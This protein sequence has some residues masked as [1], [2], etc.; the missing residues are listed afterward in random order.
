MP[1]RK[2]QSDNVQPSPSLKQKLVSFAGRFIPPKEVN[3][4]RAVAAVVRSGFKSNG[5][6]NLSFRSAAQSYD[7]N[8][9]TVRQRFH[10]RPSHRDAAESQMRVN[11]AQE[12]IIKEHMDECAVRGIPLGPN[13]VKEAAT[14]I[15]GQLCGDRWYRGFRERNPDVI[16]KVA[17]PLEAP[18][19]QALNRS[20]VKAFF[21][22]LLLLI[23]QYH[24][25]PH[26]IYN[27]D[28]KGIMLGKGSKPYVLVDRNIRTVS[29]LENGNR[30]N[31]TVIECICA[32][33]T[34]IRPCVIFKG[35]KCN[36]EWGRN[37]ECNARY[38]L[39]SIVSDK[40]LTTFHSISFSD[41][42]WTDQELGY[43][44]L[45]KDF[46]PA[47]VN[48]AGEGWRLLILDGHNS[49][50]TYPFCIFAKEHKIL[51]VCLPP[52]TTHVL[53]PC[54]VGV[55]GPL[56]SA[57]RKQVTLASHEFVKITPYNFIEF[58]STARTTSVTPHTIVRAFWKTGISPF[59]PSIIPE[60][61]FAPSRNTTVQAAPTVSM[62]LPALLE[63]VPSEP[64]P[65]AASIPP[66]A[67]TDISDDETA[68]VTPAAY[69]LV[70]KP[71]SPALN[72]P[73]SAWHAYAEATETYM[74][75]CEAALSSGYA[76]QALMQQ[77]NGALRSRLHDK[78][79][80]K[81]GR[82]EVADGPRHMTDNEM[83]D[84]LKRRDFRDEVKALGT[85]VLK[86][87]VAKI[88]ELQRKFL[89]EERE[90]EK[91]VVAARKAAEREQ[92][93]AEKAAAAARKAAEREQRGA[94]KAAVAAR[95]A[96][97]REHREAEKAAEKE[98]KETEKARR[99]A[100]KA[101]R[102]AR[103]GG[104]EAARKKK[105]EE[106]AK[107]KQEGTAV[108]IRTSAKKRKA[109]S[110]SDQTKGKKRRTNALDNAA[111]A[112]APSVVTETATAPRTCPKP[113]PVGKA[114]LMRQTRA[115]RSQTRRYVS[116]ET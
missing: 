116:A 72:A 42:G 63:P 80:T 34:S 75:Q 61:A 114:A 81:R 102:D 106:A 97:E 56:A 109:T 98:R 4:L 111:L 107:Q 19:A 47:T 105:A 89:Q 11:P 10:G 1:S 6:P 76:R 20:N 30:E 41:K 91:A 83:L 59:N 29:V 51:V 85:G 9:E 71:T 24:I 87:V 53:Q 23:Q 27:M 84:A 57:W 46:H 69:R 48:R 95:K 36:L 17:H 68:P 86:P 103:K 21:D 55:F 96:A 18:R 12:R 33:G 45:T 39:H 99:A 104:L 88:K 60:Q 90:A 37:N 67:N 43:L 110:S 7:A 32:D 38:V 52:H 82:K 14:I 74:A 101:E 40:S 35:K 77:E 26:N 115:T 58:Y 54:D 22:M 79:Q 15:S 100:E 70:D 65:T 113:R 28:E 13:G 44:W 108:G 31:I 92:K 78:R 16:G 50:L 8:Y 25:L 94:E 62:D 64:H 49:H 93:E 66:L 2:K 3:V 73:L 112:P 5:K